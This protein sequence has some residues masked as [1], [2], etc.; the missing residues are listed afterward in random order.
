MTAPVDLV[1]SRRSISIRSCPY[2]TLSTPK[3]QCQC[4]LVDHRQPHQAGEGQPAAHFELGVPSLDTLKM[5]ATHACI[6]KALTV[7]FQKQKKGHMALLRERSHV[8]YA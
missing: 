8:S 6:A 5:P 7:V 3:G 2:K 1:V 4:F